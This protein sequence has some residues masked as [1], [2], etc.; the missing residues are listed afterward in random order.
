MK[1][2]TVYLI[3]DGYDYNEKYY[4]QNNVV[5]VNRKSIFNDGITTSNNPAIHKFLSDSD[6]KIRKIIKSNSQE[7]IYY[8]TNSNPKLWWKTFWNIPENFINSSTDLVILLE[9]NNR[10][11][12]ITHGHGRFILNPLAIVYDFGLKTAL[13]LLD[14]NK[15]KSADLFTPSEIGLRTKKKSGKSTTIDE[16][17][18]NIYNSLLKNISGQVNSEFEDYFKNVNGADSIRFNFNGNKSE[19]INIVKTLL[20]KY[21]LKSY[22]KKGFSWVDNFR[23]ITDKGLKSILD[24]TLV[25][26]INNKNDDIILQYPEVIESD[27]PL[28]YRYSKINNVKKDVTNFPELDIKNQYYKVLID[29]KI[30]I[31]L[32]D[33]KRQHIYSVDMDSNKDIDSKK[34]YQCLYFDFHHRSNHYFIES[35]VWYKVDNDFIKKIDTQNN[36]IISSS[37]TSN[38]K[39]NKATISTTAVTRKKH[40]EYIFNEQL[41]Q[42]LNKNAKAQLLD[43][44]LVRQIEVCD[45][46]SNENSELVLYHNKYKYGSSALSHMFSQGYVSGEYLTDLDF[47][48]EANKCIQD[49]DLHF[50][51]K[52]ILDRSKITIIFG[53]ITKKDRKGNFTIPLFSKIN[54]NM[55]HRNITLLG[56]KSE[57]VYFE[58]I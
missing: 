1:P 30:K 19:L 50:S 58:V 49:K 34:I 21:L 18:I 36:Q 9:I 37:R 32:N 51:E 13:N 35:G 48:K 24:Q 44:K 42:H 55:F 52:S 41:T 56:Y 53:V 29:H 47:R 23:M 12:V 17:D 7:N 54:L 57:L 3:K 45:V 6:I 11:V 28:Y 22:Q 33:L 10:K 43:T 40:K 26:E 39:Y 15:V 8:R 2:F 16:Y 31:S 25:R 5:R 27:T 4:I 38:V 46:I 20:D 14:E